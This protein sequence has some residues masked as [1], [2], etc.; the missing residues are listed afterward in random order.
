MN[1][2]SPSPASDN[3]FVR[4]E[5]LKAPARGPAAAAAAEDPGLYALAPVPVD[6]AGMQAYVAA[7]LADAQA[8][9]LFC[10]PSFAARGDGWLL[11]TPWS[12][13]PGVHATWNGGP[14]PRNPSAWPASLV[15]A[16][17]GDPPDVVEIGHVWLAASAVRTEANTAACLLLMTHAFEAWRV[18]RLT[19]KTDAP[20]GARAR[21]S[22]VWRAF[23]GD[24]A[25]AP[26]GRGRHRADTAMFS[27]LPA[28]WPATKLRL[29]SALANVDSGGW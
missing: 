10:S 1:A 16:E 9:R 18:H 29:E 6:A 12:A 20:T 26:A 19:L 3:A 2:P 25:R 15:A 11:A 4:L 27:I 21:R 22:S 7:A 24:P 14:G 28:E 23:R 13:R 8:G 17:I 5:L